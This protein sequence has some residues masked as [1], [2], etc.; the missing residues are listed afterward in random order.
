MMSQAKKL[1]EEMDE[2]L[3]KKVDFMFR[4]V[5]QTITTLVDKTKVLTKRN[6]IEDTTNVIAD[7][8]SLKQTSDRLMSEADK[9]QDLLI[10]QDKGEL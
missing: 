3:P 5:R 6:L 2:K 7:A 10:K 1:L 4:A 8:K 9:L